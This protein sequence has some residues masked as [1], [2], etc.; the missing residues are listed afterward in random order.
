M[1]LIWTKVS[2]FHRSCMWI[3]KTISQLIRRCPR[4]CLTGKGLLDDKRHESLHFYVTI[5]V[6]L[7]VSVSILKEEQENLCVQSPTLFP[8]NPGVSLDTEKKCAVLENVQKFSSDQTSTLPYHAKRRKTWKRPLHG[9][10]ILNQKVPFLKKKKTIPSILRSWKA[11][12][13]LHPAWARSF[14]DR[15]CLTN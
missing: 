1:F 15:A 13:T 2:T 14:P 6:Q 5:S 7:K 9:A 8:L 12:P 11:L 3:K 4:M 10:L